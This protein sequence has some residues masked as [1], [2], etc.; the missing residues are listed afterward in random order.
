MMRTVPFAAL[1]TNSRA[2][3]SSS[4]RSTRNSVERQTRENS[5]LRQS[6]R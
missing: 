6:Q 5:E 4:M 1:R 2:V 3:S